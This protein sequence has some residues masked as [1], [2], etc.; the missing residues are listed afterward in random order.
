MATRFHF[1]N[2]MIVSD[3][4]IS[5]A[6][7]YLAID[8]HPY[9]LARKDVVDAENECKRTFAQA[10]LDADG[11]VDARKATAELSTKYQTAKANEEEAILSLER[12]K[13][14]ARAAE[15]LIEVWRSENANVRAAERIR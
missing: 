4:N 2:S 11:S 14:R 9:A 13:A 8:P 3:K 10:F 7:A 15:M 12:H 6:L 5:D 1:D